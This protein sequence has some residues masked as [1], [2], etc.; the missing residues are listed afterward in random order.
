MGRAELRDAVAIPLAFPGMRSALSYLFNNTD[1]AAARIL[2]DSMKSSIE[3][4]FDTNLAFNSIGVMG[5]YVN[6]T[7]IGSGKDDLPGYLNWLMKKCL[8]SDLGGFSLTFTS[9]SRE[10]NAFIIV[11]GG[12]TSGGFDWIYHMGVGYSAHI[13]TSTVKDG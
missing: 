9:I 7:Y 12:K 2:A 5:S 8:S 10:S 1:M 6:V 4:E 13:V 3:E 11:S